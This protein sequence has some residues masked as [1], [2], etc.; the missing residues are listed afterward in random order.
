MLNINHYL[1]SKNV[2]AFE[3]VLD[4]YIYIDNNIFLKFEI[5]M[6]I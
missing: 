6:L 4:T 3:Y 5:F 2:L 1:V